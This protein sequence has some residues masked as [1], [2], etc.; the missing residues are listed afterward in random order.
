MHLSVAATRAMTM[1][2]VL[3]SDLMHAWFVRGA[4]VAFVGDACVATN[5]REARRGDTALRAGAAIR[6]GRVHIARGDRTAQGKIG[7]TGAA[8]FVEGHGFAPGLRLR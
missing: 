4:F 3:A 8:V 6:A 5:R 7:A 2:D 1:A